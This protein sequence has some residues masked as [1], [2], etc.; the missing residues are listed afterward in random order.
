MKV[1]TAHGKSIVGSGETAAAIERLGKVAA[2]DLRVR[3]GQLDEGRAQSR[4]TVE[5]RDVL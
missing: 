3:F 4:V 5:S 2:L 1:Q